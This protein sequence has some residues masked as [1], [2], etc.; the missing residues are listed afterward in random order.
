MERKKI[1]ETQEK[2]MEQ[3]KTEIKEVKEAVNEIKNLL[4]GKI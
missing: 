3:L 2:K 4:M 1:E